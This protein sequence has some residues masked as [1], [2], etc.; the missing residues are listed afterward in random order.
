MGPARA[1]DADGEFL[2]HGVSY[3]DVEESTTLE[4]AIR[5]TL[6]CGQEISGNTLTDASSTDRLDSYA[7]IV[8][9]WSGPEVGYELGVSSSGEIELEL[10][11]DGP[12]VIDHDLILLKRAAGVC[13]ASDAI[14]VGY[15]SLSFEPESGATYTLV[16]DGYNGAEGE[17]TVRMS[18]L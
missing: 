2:A 7:D 10:L 1:Y 4:C 15:T 13:A 5:D 9:L 8:G 16:V 14:Q 11:Y 6:S 17:Y 18:C 12:V 3:I